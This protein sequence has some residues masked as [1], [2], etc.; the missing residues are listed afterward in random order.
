MASKKLYSYSYAFY[1][2]F[3]I[4]SLKSDANLQSLYKYDSVTVPVIP[5]SVV[6]PFVT[7]N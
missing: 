3:M 1:K 2:C 4:F 5:F 7:S 6:N